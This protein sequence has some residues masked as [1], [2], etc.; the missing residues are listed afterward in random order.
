MAATSLDYQS[1]SSQPSNSSHQHVQRQQTQSQSQS[2]PQP[3]PQ[4]QS[5]ALPTPPP[6]PPTSRRRLKKK[7]KDPFLDLTFRTSAPAPPSSS[8]TPQDASESAPGEH[9]ASQ[10]RITKILQI[11]QTPFL[12]TSFIISFALISLADRAYRARVP[13]IPGLVPE[14]YPSS[15]SDT[16]PPDQPHQQPSSGRWKRRDSAHVGPAEAL[17]PGGRVGRGGREEAQA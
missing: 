8:P 9:D 6:S 3:H 5:T 2:Q 17:N 10:W 1:M 7:E 4:S 15:D 13:P 16:S 14:P 11:L 12:I